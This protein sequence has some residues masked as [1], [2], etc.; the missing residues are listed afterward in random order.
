MSETARRT[1]VA[2]MVVL[3]VVVGALALWKL[4]ILLALLF[5]AF[6]VASAMRPG[7]GAPRRGVPR[8]AA[9]L[10]HYTALVAALGLLLWAVVPRAISRCRR[11]SGTPR[12]RPA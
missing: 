2:S 7:R 1:F 4:K 3:G 10:L 11:R 8:G 6:T 12:T 5:P 9:V